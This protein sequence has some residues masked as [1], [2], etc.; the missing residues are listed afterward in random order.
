MKPP[1]TLILSDTHLQPSTPQANLCFLTLLKTQAR[2]AD[3]LYILGDLFE[4]W[5]GDDDNS[6]FNQQIKSALWQLTHSGVPV[7]FMAGNR[8]FL[9]SKCFA[10]QTGVRQLPD[11]T[12]IECYGK[13][14]LLMHGDSL[15]TDDLRHQSFRRKTNNRF[16]RRLFLA[17]PLTLRRTIAK[18]IR[19]ISYQRGQRLDDDIMDVNTRSVNTILQQYKPDAL[20]HG[21]TH[22]CAKHQHEVHGH[23]I[24]RFVLDSWH[25]HGNALVLRP[26]QAPEF[27]QFNFN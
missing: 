7:Y 27:V 6:S 10:Q 19:S 8:D 16:Y 9:V 21:H 1:Y 11:P 4:Y 15:C 24:P 20:I 26:N 22:R 2:F 3:A 5:I 13:R 12:V 18:R 17:L 23:T 25:H 14:L